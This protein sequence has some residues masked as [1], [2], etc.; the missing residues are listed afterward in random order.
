MYVLFFNFVCIL[1]SQSNFLGH[2]PGVGWV[3]QARITLKGSWDHEEPYL[4][5]LPRL[6]K[7]ETEAAKRATQD[8]A[9]HSP[10]Y[11]YVVSVLTLTVWET[12]SCTLGALKHIPL[13]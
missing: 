1:Q 9:A 6:E 3:H 13:A 7:S 2:P 12:A 5:A 4:T 8:G 11:V 10:V